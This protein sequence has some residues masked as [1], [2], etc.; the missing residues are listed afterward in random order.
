MP[1]P[2]RTSRKKRVLLILAIAVDWARI[3]ELLHQS[4]RSLARFV[5]E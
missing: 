4:Y 2:K 3:D 5:K 1:T